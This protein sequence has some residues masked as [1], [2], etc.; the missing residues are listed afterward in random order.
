LHTA[1]VENMGARS[2][3]PFRW[4]SRLT[5]RTRLVLLLLALTL[6]FLLYVALAAKRQIDTEREEVRQRM[7]AV[8]RLAAARLNDHVGDV[9]QMLS[10]LSRVVGTSPDDTARNDALLKALTP[11]LPEAT[12]NVA[13]WSATGVNIGTLNPRLRANAIDV[14]RFKFFA[15]G[16]KGV[17]MSS[18][19]P[20]FSM[21]TDQRVAIFGM[22]IVRDGRVVG[23][24]GASTWLQPLQALV[25]PA[26]S[27]PPATVVTLT[28]QRGIVLARSIDPD[29]WV[30]KDLMRRASVAFGLDVRE[31]ARDGLSADGVE[32]IAGFTTADQVGWQVYV[33]IP[34]E[35]ALAP[36]MRRFYENL[37]VGGLLIV[38]GVLLAAR[39]AESIASPLRHLSG[40]AAALA[41]G[42]L[43]HRSG[44][45]Q[46][47]EIG[48]L[49]ATLNRMADALE[50]RTA[51]AETSRERLRQIT[52]NLPVLISYVDAEQRFRFANR[53]Y[54]DWLGID[55]E[56]V[57]GRT[58]EEV[59]GAER[60]AAF[61][62][63]VEAA[64]AGRRVSYERDFES[65]T[66][67]R[68]VEVTEVPHIAAGGRVKGLFVLVHDVTA[69]REAEQRRARSEERLS[70]AL[71]GSGLALFDADLR[72]DRV[73]LSAQAAAIRGEK[74]HETTATSAS[75]LGS[76]H[77]EDRQRSATALRAALRGHVP[78]YEAEVR[79]RTVNG[80]WIWV[81]ALGRVVERDPGGRAIRLA[82][83]FADI[84][85]RKANE[86]R[87]R[88][89]AEFDALTGLPNRALFLDRLQQAIHRA[90]RRG[91]QMALFFLDIDHFKGVNDSLGHGAGDH[92][93][94][95][96]AHTLCDSVRTSDT[97]ARLGGD[98]FTVILEDLHGLED[99]K[100]VAQTLVTRARDP[101]TLA[102]G[103]RLTVSTSI[104]IAMLDPGDPDSEHLLRQADVALYEAKRRG[105]DGYAC[106]AEVASL[107]AAAGAD[108]SA[109][110]PKI[111]HA[112]RP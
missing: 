76:I 71:E 100:A 72:A 106:S 42:D 88:H 99:A 18:D 8:A 49:A 48:L 7:L 112:Q 30:G 75:L 15:D 92:L 46:G 5:I 37:A 108:A 1:V 66:G 68:R 78:Q 69:S 22:P 97:V 10:V 55:P 27:L 19:A 60:Y 94:Q 104:G 96:F 53:V 25:T 36:V 85:E 41:R 47:G 77:P 24:V 65:I 31:G 38:I 90:R 105:R 35:I 64:L 12:S 79:V 39:V 87:L 21:L 52:D 81:R 57:L 62:H 103:Q 44:V 70:L 50:E 28:D 2:V 33:G 23:V 67:K 29:K 34:T 111:R 93:L 74:P 91:T 56:A 16:M 102:D 11:T 9:R 83:T 89:M 82:G 58:I 54:R 45:Q 98:E 73:Y 61:R 59:Y 32:R 20:A 43:S 86:E 101:V 95:S 40:D 63:H 107:A 3:T 14:N 17:E 84:S 6:P 110:A 26:Q 4:A 80:S 109:N 51:S 13:V